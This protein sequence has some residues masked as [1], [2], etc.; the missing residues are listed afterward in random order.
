MPASYTFFFRL[1]HENVVERFDSYTGENE[2]VKP[3]PLSPEA[4]S[5]QDLTKCQPQSQLSNFA[6][7]QIY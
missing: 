1:N 7:H 2:P 6:L 4:S 3:Y 5:G